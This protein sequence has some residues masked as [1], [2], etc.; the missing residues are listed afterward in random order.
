M[1]TEDTQAG[2]GGSMHHTGVIHGRFQVLHN[3]HMKYLL[4]GKARCRRLVVGITNPDPNYTRHDDA[5]PARSSSQ[6]NPLT[7]YE[8]HLMVTAALADEGLG[9]DDF[10]V[11]PFPINVPELYRHYLPLDAVF[12]LTI[13]DPWGERKLRIFQSMGL[14]TEVM[15]R[16]PP[17]EKGLSSTD[18]RRRMAAGEPWEHLVPPAVADLVRALNIVDRLS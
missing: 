1:K 14:A 11:V 15:W 6:A 3:D 5:D 12:Y 17:E 16:R 2:K 4:A 8:R 18:I 13:Y 7:Y 9:M 10:T